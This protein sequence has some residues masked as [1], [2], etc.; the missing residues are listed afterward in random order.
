MHEVLVN[1]LF[2]L[3]QE[4]VL[5]G[6]LTVRNNHVADDWDVKQPN[7]QTNQTPCHPVPLVYSY[8][9]TMTGLHAGRKTIDYSYAISTYYILLAV[10]K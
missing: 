5:L 8:C 3:S 7:K 10:L 6:E 1:R 4:K 9:Q 2:K